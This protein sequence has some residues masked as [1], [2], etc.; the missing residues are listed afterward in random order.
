MPWKQALDRA[1]SLA[2]LDALDPAAVIAELEAEIPDATS[3][4]E[5]EARDAALAAALDAFDAIAIRAMKV[6][7]EHA[8]ASDGSIG[9]PTRNVFAQTIVN[10]AD[11]V[12]LLGERARDLAM[13]GR[14][15]SPDG[16]ADAV[17]SAARASL[18]LRDA[19]RTGVLDLVRRLAT[20]SVP[21]ADRNARDPKLDDTQRKRWSAARRDLET[22]A[23]EPAAIGVAPMAKRMAAW[24]DQLDEAAVPPEPALA[25]LIEID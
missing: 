8:L 5:L 17:M 24:P 4:P 12:A 18:A 23:R 25:D 15:P 11:N 21:L 2:Q 7:L 9:P 3:L 22:I 16:V 6:R 1:H 13:R 14:A 10:Y 20:A 19:L